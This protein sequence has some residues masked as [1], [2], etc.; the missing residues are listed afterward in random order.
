MTM[1]LEE[2]PGFK[3]MLATIVFAMLLEDF[4]FWAMH[5]LF[6]VQ[7]LYNWIHKVHHDHYTPF[8]VSTEH[9]H[10]FDF[11]FGSLLPGSLATIILQKKMHIV[12]MLIWTLLRVTESCYAHC[13]YE[14]P[15]TPY[16]LFPFMVASRYHDFHHSH[17]LG[18]YASRFIFWD[19][20]FGDNIHYYQFLKDQKRK[21]QNKL[22]S[23]LDSDSNSTQESN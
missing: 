22:L 20:V 9:Q 17:N 23:Q 5:K 4:G 13:G 8:N 1:S 19:L 10:P 21:K 15:W 18:N 2:L 6:H 14:I 16:R 7:P 12:C 3:K 11:I